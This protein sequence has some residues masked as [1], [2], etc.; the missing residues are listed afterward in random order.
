MTRRQASAFATGRLKNRAE[1]SAPKSGASAPDRGQGEIRL[2]AFASIRRW[3]D[4]PG[5][6]DNFLSQKP[7]A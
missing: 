2:G 4:L 1:A 7:A 6:C 5:V 3:K